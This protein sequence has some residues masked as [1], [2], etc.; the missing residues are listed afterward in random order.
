MIRLEGVSFR[1]RAAAR[2]A[3]SDVTCHLRPGEL[4]GLLGRSGAGRST[5]AA[6]LNGTIPHLTRG[7][8]AGRVWIGGED[9]R[10]KRPRDLADRIGFVFQDFESQ[11]FST[12]VTLEVAFGPENLGVDRAEIARRTDRCLRLVRLDHLGKKAPA[13]LS[14]GQ[15][16]RLALASV[17]ALMPQALVLDEPTSDLDP[18]GRRERGLCF[19]LCPVG[20]AVRPAGFSRLPAIRF[21]CPGASAVRWMLEVHDVKPDP[22][23][24]R[25]NLV[26]NQP[27]AEPVG[28]LPVPG[29]VA[30]GP[31]PCTAAAP[32]A[33]EER[34]LVARARDR[35]EEAFR[36]LVD[37]HRDRA[38]GLALRIGSRLPHPES[39]FSTM[40]VPVGFF[41]LFVGLFLIIS[42]RKALTQVL[43]YLVLEN[44]AYVLGLAMVAEIPVLVEAGVLLD[45]F[46]AVFVM[47]IAIHQIT[48]EFRSTDVDKLTA[49]KG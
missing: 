18:A 13:A 2:P 42:R 5:L 45:A 9:I 34:D 21:A 8:F 3:L 22:P 11:L 20:R 4:V 30:A 23:L 24:G 27:A 7:D 38:L 19:R 40:S 44:G 6:T 31:A 46:V 41:T 10:S 43:G 37:L 35:D 39:G 16:Q 36:V 32:G 25:S 33:I 29:A 1:Y 49:L 12:N 47:Q 48:A 28:A 14:G 17:L 26:M 15:K